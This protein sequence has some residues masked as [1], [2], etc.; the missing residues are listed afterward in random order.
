M[1]DDVRKEA[2]YAF[3]LQRH[4]ADILWNWVQFQET[5]WQSN[6]IDITRFTSHLA[7]LATEPELLFRYSRRNWQKPFA[8]LSAQ[9]LTQLQLLS[10][11]T[12]E[13]LSYLH[14]HRPKSKH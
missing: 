2:N 3:K 10:Q 11:L 13:S 6:L 1:F 9:Y 7:G 5:C 12:I 14:K 8:T 4:Y